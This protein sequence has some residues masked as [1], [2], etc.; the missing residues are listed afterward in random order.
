MFD[1]CDELFKDRNFLKVTKKIL[2]SKLTP[3]SL[4]GEEELIN[5]E[6]R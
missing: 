4:L 1:E 3:G 5:K 2:L 6:Y